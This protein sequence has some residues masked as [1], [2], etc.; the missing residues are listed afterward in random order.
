MSNYL[1]L[2]SLFSMSGLGMQDGRLE[3]YRFYSNIDGQTDAQIILNQEYAQAKQAL[4][5]MEQEDQDLRRN[6]LRAGHL[7]NIKQATELNKK[8]LE[9]LKKIKS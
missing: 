1:I 7:Y 9:I 8:H 2:L 3:L 6:A 5:L 4:L